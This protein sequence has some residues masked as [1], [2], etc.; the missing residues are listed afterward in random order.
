M[1]LKRFACLNVFFSTVIVST[2]IYANELSGGGYLY[3]PKAVSTPTVLEY[4]PSTKERNTSSFAFRNFNS[5][6][7]L[8][9]DR[10]EAVQRA[11]D[12]AGGDVKI[13]KVI[14]KPTSLRIDQ[15]KNVSPLVLGNVDIKS[16]GN[17]SE[18][19]TISLDEIMN[20]NPIRPSIR[21]IYDS[22]IIIQVKNIKR[23][24]AMDEGFINVEK[25]D[26]NQ[27]IIKA[28]RYGGTFLNVW[29]DDGRR[30]IYVGIVFPEVHNSQS[31]SGSKSKEHEA[32]FRFS[33]SNDWDTYYY[34]L[35][36]EDLKRQSY[37]FLQTFALTG[38]TPYGY[39]DSSL[40]E[41]N[42][43]GKSSI[44][45]YTLGLNRIPVEGTSDFNVRVFDAN[46]SL[47]PLTLPNTRLNGVFGDI[48]ILRDMV[49]LS[50]SYGQKKSYFATLSQTSSA[51]IKSYID[52]YQLTLFPKDQDNQI[53]LNVA[54]GFG[55]Q[56]ENY[57]TKKVYSVEARKK[58]LNVLLNGEFAEGDHHNASLA[59]IKWQNKSFTTALNFRQTNK[60]FTT[61]TALPSNQGE[62]GVIWTT[63]VDG[64]NVT[65]QT[66]VNVYREYLF[67]NPNDPEALNYDLSARLRM[68]LIKKFWSDTSMY[69]VH[70]PGEISP[71]INIGL[72]QRIS[73]AINLLGFKNT[74]IY[75]GGALQRTRYE[76][77]S[78]SAYDRYA[79]L[80][81]IQI[82]LINNLSVYANFEDSWIH[83]IDS[84]N[85]INPNVFNTGFYF[86]QQLTNKVSGNFDMFYR[87]ESGAS[88]TTSYLS[89]ED[90]AGL[91]LGF[92]YN[93]VNDANLFFDA[94]SRRVWPKSDGNFT[95]TDL[96]LRFG[97][98]LSF[99]VLTRGW[100]PHG[101]IRGHVYKDQDGNG[102]Y[103]KGEQGIPLVKINAGDRQVVT[104]KEGF[105]R[106]DVRA[107]SVSVTPDTETL[108]TG[109]VF[110]TPSARTV[111]IKP[112][113]GTQADF[114]L[115]S[116]TGV[117][118]LVFIDKNVNGV[119]DS[120][121][122]FIKQA[123]IVLDKKYISVSD[124]QGAFYF[125]NI[126]EGVHTLRIDIN[127][128]PIDTLPKVKLENRIN[129]SEGTTFLFHIP[130]A[131][132]D[133]K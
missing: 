23:F 113:G 13:K 72:D 86:S 45:S 102:R 71:R 105:Y 42:L 12:E 3:L 48:N 20:S 85:N 51:N 126:A 106:M 94:R 49:G 67:S 65:E 32:P 6:I 55:S 57:L 122:Q 41:E 8:E 10:M 50:F 121:D 98:R 93:P 38:Q 25:I 44:S 68:P 31:N 26:H 125:R 9:L 83:E 110:S 89:G 39:F 15:K 81:G 56:H 80:T 79:A 133:T 46:R 92:S 104:D 111:D 11:L 66:V 64:Q 54:E 34:G 123:K 75:F 128:L 76:F 2:Q 14:V 114:G 132:K 33:Y 63:N 97:L 99:D 37:S 17:G 109:V 21:L 95:Y 96:D 74:N 28:L 47:S 4:T 58:I 115:N 69:Y 24:L 43:S 62:V 29:D 120:S 16:S 18:I 130:L 118:G 7:D 60:N 61:V 87:T 52:A 27:I 59:G 129:V 124:S 30:T 77:S 107:K 40:S 84:G 5:P 101:A 116:Q 70:T 131:T 36:N 82:P 19:K 117:Y 108:P 78:S 88:G 35:K 53:S 112:W 1:F 73:R 91:S 127:S 103:D 100:D 119:P 22:S 90:S